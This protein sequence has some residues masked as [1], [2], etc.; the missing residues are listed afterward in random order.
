[1]H[2]RC[3]KSFG[4]RSILGV[5]GPFAFSDILFCHPF[6][7]RHGLNKARNLEEIKCR[8]FVERYSL[9]HLK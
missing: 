6:E 9:S 4:S 8:E 2:H 7:G 5:L 3:Y 1:M